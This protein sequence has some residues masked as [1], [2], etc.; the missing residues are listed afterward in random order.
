MPSR[1]QP[2]HVAAHAGM[3]LPVAILRRL[4]RD[5]LSAEQ[6]AARLGVS[7]A[8]VRTVL[9]RMHRGGEVEPA[10][11]TRRDIRWRARV[12]PCAAAAGAMHGADE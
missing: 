7:L 8:T 12:A 10:G 6:L 4:Q 9:S 11:Y 1:Q 2:D 3:T 5:T